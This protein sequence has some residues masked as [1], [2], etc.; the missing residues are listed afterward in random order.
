KIRFGT[1]FSY[2]VKIPPD[3]V[4]SVSVPAFSLQLLIENAIKHNIL[5]EENPLTLHIDYLPEGLIQVKNNKKLKNIREASSSIG[6]KNLAERYK[7][8]SGNDI[9]VIDD[10]TEFIVQIQ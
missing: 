6:L 4:G 1:A 9:K 3:V 7:M 10:D 5:T 8:I 2:A